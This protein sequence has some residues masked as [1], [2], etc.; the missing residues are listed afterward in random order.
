MPRTC[1]QITS[2]TRPFLE[3]YTSLSLTGY[4]IFAELHNLGANLERRG[5]S[6]DNV[7]ELVLGP[8]QVKCLERWS[9]VLRTYSE[10]DLGAHC[11]K[12]R[13]IFPSVKRLVI[14]STLEDHVA[15]F[16]RDCFGERDLEIVH[17][18][19]SARTTKAAPQMRAQ[20]FQDFYA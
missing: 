9:I 16:I 4:E 6:F 14:F 18:T 3:T 2:E 11:R 7:R 15:E 12:L 1:R 8:E 20:G 5:R 10:Q 13:S 19:N 17:G